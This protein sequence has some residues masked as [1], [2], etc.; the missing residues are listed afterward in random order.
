MGEA[1]REDRKYLDDSAIPRIKFRSIR[2]RT[3][4]ARIPNVNAISSRFVETFIG[5][6]ELP[7]AAAGTLFW[8]RARRLFQNRHKVERRHRFGRKGTLLI[9]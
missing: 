7:V 2:W 4:A 3:F 6:Q 1:N 9:I 5:F 8:K